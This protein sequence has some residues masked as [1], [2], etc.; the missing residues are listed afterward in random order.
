M[1]A[2]PRPGGLAGMRHIA[3]RVQDMAKSRAFYEGLLGMRV[4]WEP[5]PDNV[6]LS[7]G[8]DNLALHSARVAAGDAQ[9]L[10]HLGFILDARQ[11]VDAWQNYLEANGCAILKRVKDHRDGSRSFYVADPDGNVV[12]ML[13]EPNLCGSES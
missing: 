5:D 4:V 3:L 10:D 1:R 13:F 2:H 11:A 7:S 12:Q 6:Y 9:R 8:S